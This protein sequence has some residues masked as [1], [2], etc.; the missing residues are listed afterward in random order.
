[1]QR[2]SGS[3]TYET[4]RL[5]TI[6]AKEYAMEYKQYEEPKQQCHSMNV[7]VESYRYTRNNMDFK[8]KQRGY[9]MKTNNHQHASNAHVLSIAL[10]LLCLFVV[11][12]CASQTARA[13]PA[14]PLPVSHTHTTMIRGDAEVGKAIFEGRKQ[15]YAFVPCSTCHYVE[16]HQGVLLGPN[17]AG[18]G[19]RAAE[20]VP[21]MSAEEYLIESIKFPDAYVVDGFPASTMNQA[22]DDRLTDEEI[23]HVVAYLMTL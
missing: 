2:A 7:S 17:M 3:F 23:A 13:V 6:I 20:R 9:N 10:L 8:A 5:C 22:Y 21:G 14:R 19:K 15:I 1:M 16:R 4:M 18:L 11:S 12:A